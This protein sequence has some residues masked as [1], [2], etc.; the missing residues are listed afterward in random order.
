MYVKCIVGNDDIQC[1][2]F[3]MKTQC[4][5]GWRCPFSYY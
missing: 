4:N 2:L 5:E 1:N 3:V